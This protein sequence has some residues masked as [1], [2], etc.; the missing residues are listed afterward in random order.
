MC[1]L[2]KVAIGIPLVL[3]LLLVIVMEITLLTSYQPIV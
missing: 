3:Y 1:L 2:I